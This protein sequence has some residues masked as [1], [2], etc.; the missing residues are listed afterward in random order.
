M[1]LNK[2]GFTLIELL[3]VIV[4]LAIILVI[5]V[6]R[7]LDVINKAAQG[8]VDQTAKMAAKYMEKDFALKVLEG[9]VPDA[10]PTLTNCPSEVGHD[11]TQMTC[12]YTMT[13]TDGVPTYTVTVTGTAGRV[14]GKTATFPQP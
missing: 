11:T 7:I 6:P 5:A 13:L 8:S 4:V 3:A 2:K 14:N 12:Q 10:V 1:K 9:T